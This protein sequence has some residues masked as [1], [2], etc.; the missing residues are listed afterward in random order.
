MSR[1]RCGGSSGQRARRAAAADLEAALGVAG[2]PVSRALLARLGRA[3]LV[4]R[5]DLQ[6]LREQADCRPTENWTA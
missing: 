2:I 3:Y 6:G 5:Q 1:R 4:L